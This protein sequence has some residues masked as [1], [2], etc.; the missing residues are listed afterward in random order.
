MS[1]VDAMMLAL[2]WVLVIEGFM[3]MLAP[4][5]WKKAVRRVS[6]EPDASLRITGLLLVVFGLA[7][8]WIA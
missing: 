6:E 4:G 7:L 2:G 3:P 1:R 5:F 8:V